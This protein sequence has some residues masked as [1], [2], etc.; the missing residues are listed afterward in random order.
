MDVSLPADPYHPPRIELRAGERGRLAAS[1]GAASDGLGTGG[2]LFYETWAGAYAG[3]GAVRCC[4]P[5]SFI[6]AALDAEVWC[7]SAGRDTS[8]TLS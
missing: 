4:Q 7:G 5:P 8:M 3:R 1:H 6:S 2:L